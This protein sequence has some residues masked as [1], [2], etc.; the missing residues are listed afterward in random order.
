ML[1]LYAAIKDPC[2]SAIC[3][4]EME[5][6]EEGKKYWEPRLPTAKYVEISES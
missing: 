6:W 2:Y 1:E 5:V 4:P 3:H